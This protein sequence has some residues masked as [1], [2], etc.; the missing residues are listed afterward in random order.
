[1]HAQRIDAEDPALESP[2]N[3]LLADALR[4]RYGAEALAPIRA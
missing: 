3:A 2:E 1:M 4:G